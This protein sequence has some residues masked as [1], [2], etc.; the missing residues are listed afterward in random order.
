MAD[1]GQDA[2]RFPVLPIQVENPSHASSSQQLRTFA[3][4]RFWSSRVAR[5]LDASATQHRILS[6]DVSL[7]KCAQR[8]S[9]SE[10]LQASLALSIIF[11]SLPASWLR[12]SAVVLGG[13]GCATIHCSTLKCGECGSWKYHAAL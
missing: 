8:Q 11:A 7:S 6:E 10:F 13:S 5:R 9:W 3:R 4:A 12:C 1:S 2:P